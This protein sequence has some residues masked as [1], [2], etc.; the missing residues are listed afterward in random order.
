MAFGLPLPICSCGVVPVYQSLIHR[1][2]PVSAGIAFLVATPELGMDAVLLSLPLLGVRVTLVR[3]LA[4]VFVALSAGLILGAMGTQADREKAGE[5]GC[6]SG[7]C[8][9]QGPILGVPQR[10]AAAIRYGAVELLDHT[11][12]WILVG[13]L[14]AAVVQPSLDL[15]SLT[16]LPGTWQ[17]LLMTLLGMP[18][19]VCAAGATPIAAVLIAKGVSPGAALAFLLAGPVTNATT[20]GVLAKL[21]GKRT[22]TLFVV[23]L[24]AACGAAGLLTDLLSQGFLANAAQ[25]AV[26]HEEYGLISWLSVGLLGVLAVLSLLRQ[27]P[28]GLAEQVVGGTHDHDHGQGAGH[29]GHTCDEAPEAADH[30]HGCH[31]DHGCSGG[32]GCHESAPHAHPSPSESSQET[33]SESGKKGGCCGGS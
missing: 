33:P 19:Y 15:T 28:R 7:C 5:G 30:D 27:G 29:H 24:V 16:S 9:R 11:G 14:I 2:V 13:L 31:H 17:V 6:G 20:F 1:G 3:V 26:S 12:P 22:A 10:L 8:E 18:L 4:A 25:E 32:V 21:H 23:T